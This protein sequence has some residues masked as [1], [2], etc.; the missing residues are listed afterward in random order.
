MKT[1]RK[2]RAV[3]LVLNPSKHEAMV[4]LNSNDSIVTFLFLK[5]R[6]WSFLKSLL[7]HNGKKQQV[8]IG[9]KESCYSK[10]QYLEPNGKVYKTAAPFGLEVWGGYEAA[11]T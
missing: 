4:L 11:L 9:N 10:S 7:P 2:N 1:T 3:T 6:S 8:K 5:N